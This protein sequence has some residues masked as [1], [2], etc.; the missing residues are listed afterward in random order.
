MLIIFN[1]AGTGGT[2]SLY[3]NVNGS[4]G[5][6]YGASS[7]I[8]GGG[9]MSINTTLFFANTGSTVYNLNLTFNGTPTLSNNNSLT[10]IRIA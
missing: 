7:S 1:F 10:A 8:G 3:F 6:Y 9:F 2:N 4:S 5:N